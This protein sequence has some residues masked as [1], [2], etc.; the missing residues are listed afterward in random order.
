MEN[1]ENN[2]K[3]Q[4]IIIGIAAVVVLV[5]IGAGIA[6]ASNQPTPVEQTE[7]QTENNNTNTDNN[8]NKNSEEKKSEDTVKDNTTSSGKSDNTTSNSTGSSL[9][10]DTKQSISNSTSA[11]RPSLVAEEVDNKS[12]NEQDGDYT[13]VDD[14]WKY[15]NVLHGTEFVRNDAFAFRVNAKMSPA[16]T[17]DPHYKPNL[18][19]ATN[20]SESL[21]FSISVSNDWS[22]A[23]ESVSSAKERLARN[24]GN[25]CSYQI[26]DYTVLYW[27]SAKAATDSFYTSDYI[28]VWNEAKQFY[29]KIYC[30]NYSGEETARK[31]TD[32]FTF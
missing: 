11:L 29:M 31:Y 6:I 12:Y 25:N 7:E 21:H 9:S 3:K 10:D 26:D 13:K 32:L 18:E 30:D 4:K 16:Y 2:E 24:D 14:Y 22:E 23:Q 15:K 1:K 19:F 20:A 17:L 27:Y 5:L 28:L 8:D